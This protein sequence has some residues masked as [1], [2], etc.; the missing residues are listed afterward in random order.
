M[1]VAFVGGYEEQAL[2]DYF[3]WYGEFEGEFGIAVNYSGFQPSAGL[4][5]TTLSGS[6]ETD[7][8]FAT[9]TE[10]FYGFNGG[11]YAELKYETKRSPVY[12][13]L[14]GVIGDVEGVSLGLGVKF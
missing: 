10:D 1:G 3:L 14:R 2:A 11:A 8:G 12:G 9:I 7:V 5:F 6:A 13:R 4:Y